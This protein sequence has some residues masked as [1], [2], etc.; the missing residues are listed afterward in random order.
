MEAMGFTVPL[1]AWA[2][3]LSVGIGGLVALYLR[4]IWAVSTGVWSGFSNRKLMALH[5]AIIAEL[6]RIERGNQESE[7]VRA[8]KRRVLEGKLKRLKIRCPSPQH[9][10]TWRVFLMRLL[11]Y[12][13]DG[14]VK[15]ARSWLDELEKHMVEREEIK[16]DM[17]L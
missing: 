6:D 4:E 16:R 9:E 13:S 3:M 2:A 15:N 7:A 1:A 14:D 17:G 12:S 11:I 8:A 5:D 10:A